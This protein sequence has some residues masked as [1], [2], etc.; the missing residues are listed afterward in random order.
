MCIDVRWSDQTD[1]AIQLTFQPG[2]SWADLYAAV[3]QVDAWIVG[4]PH[5]VHLL[6]DLREA[7]PLPRDFM[8]VA[9]D[10][11]TTG[12]ARPN[13]GMRIII[14][15]G[16]LLRIAYGGLARVYGARITERPLH[17]VATPEDAR[18]LLAAQ[19]S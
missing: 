10:L 3:Q 7:G 2:W 6:I 18:A 11:L 12:E 15:A 17:F 16:R 13:E 1:R 5:A 14:G 19:E 8:T 4:A 9:G